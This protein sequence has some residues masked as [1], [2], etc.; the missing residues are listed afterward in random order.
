[1]AAF[2]LLGILF[3]LGYRRAWPFAL[4]IVTVAA[5]GFEA[6]QMLTPDRHARLDDA[7]VK[8]FGGIIGVGIGLVVNRFT[9]WPLPGKDDRSQ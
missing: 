8:A 6:M 1:M 2:I 3:C 5:F 7:V 9:P 4:A